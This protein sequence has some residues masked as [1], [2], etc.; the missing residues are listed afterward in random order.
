MKT[1]VVYAHPVPESFNAAV[2]DTVVAAAEEAGHDVRLV[3]LC[4]EAFDPVMSAEERHRYHD[5]GLNEAPVRDHLDHI[6]WA[7]CIL[8]VYPTWWYGLPAILKGW[9]DRVWVP[10]V[11]FVMPDGD[12]PIRPAMT[13]IRKLGIVTTC[14]A[15]WWLLWYMGHPGRMTIL[16]GI[17][18][19]CHPRCKTLWVA[20]YLMDS[21]TPQ[22][23]GAFL[24]RVRRKIAAF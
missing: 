9:L 12:Q 14:G 4:V 20:H 17:K 11:T 1:L 5:K 23:R 24:D 13:H 18:A 16:R 15:P 22:S 10:H 21:S 7:E 3:D 8:F 6:L 2:R 19:L